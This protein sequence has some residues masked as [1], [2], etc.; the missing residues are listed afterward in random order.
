MKSIGTQT[1]DVCDLNIDALSISAHKI[2]GPKGIGALFIS[3]SIKNTLRPLM[4][5]GGQ[6][7]GLRSGTPNV[8]KI[9]SQKRSENGGGNFSMFFYFKTGHTEIK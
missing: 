9:S 3:N 6:E 7:M 5:G 2:Y 4:S 8:V 1:I